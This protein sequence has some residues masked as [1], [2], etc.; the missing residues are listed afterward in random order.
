VWV[1]NLAIEYP[2]DPAFM[3]WVLERLEKGKLVAMI[4]ITK[5]AGSAP[6]GPGTKMFVDED[7]NTFGTIGGGDF[8]RKVIEEAKKAIE[9]RKPMERKVAMFRENLY[10]DV[11]ATEQLCGGVVTV[12]IDVLKPLQRLVLIGAGHVARPLAKLGK[13]LN[14]RVIVVDNFPQY[15]NKDKIPEADEIYASSDIISELDKIKLDKNDFVVIVHG[16]GA[17]EAEVLK[18][19][20]RGNV[21]PRYLGLLAGGGK[22][23]YILKALLES[24]IDPN[25][26]R[27]KLISPIGLSVGSE[28]PEE[29]AIAVM[30]EILKIDRGTQGV[31]EN[32]VPEILDQLLKGGG[33]D[34]QK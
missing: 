7:G 12:F 32:R 33:K 8:E 11:I 18:K 23:A 20:F 34:E 26:I 5:K 9:A 27:N 29:I 24:G 10:E 25:V 22:L 14:Y 2:S 4:E 1:R 15:A 6:R 13:M 31:H 21:F 28:T 3:R 30:A 16:D 19:I 17:L